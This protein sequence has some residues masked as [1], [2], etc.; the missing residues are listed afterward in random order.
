M[1][2][3]HCI[4]TRQRGITARTLAS[5]ERALAG[6]PAES[7][8]GVH[9]GMHD[10][11]RRGIESVRDDLRARFA[12]LDAEIEEVLASALMAGM[13]IGMHRKP[14]STTGGIERVGA[15]PN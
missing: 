11:A 7:P 15:S 3:E 6:H 9:P 8:A 1:M 2:D 5:F 10:A 13:G 4:L 14:G 12:E